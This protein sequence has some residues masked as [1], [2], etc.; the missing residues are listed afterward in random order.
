MKNILVIS[1]SDLSIDPRVNRQ[2][3]T[4]SKNYHVFAAGYSFSTLPKI[5]GINIKPKFNNFMQSLQ[6]FMNML[7]RR[8]ESV[9][10]D[11]RMND[12]FNHIKDSIATS[13]IDV[14]YANDISSL[15]LALKLKDV[16]NCKVI[17]DAH[18]YAPREWEDRFFWRIMHQPYVNYLCKKYIPKV[19]LFITVGDRI[20]K[21]YEL[22]FNINK[23][24]VI[25][26]APGEQKALMPSIVGD[27]KIR[28]IHHGAAIRSRKI[29]LMIEMMDYLNDDFSL[30]LM[31][32]PVD[33]KYYKKLIKLASF[34]NINIIEPVSMQEICKKINEY[35]IGVYILD[36]SKNFNHENAL[37][38]KLFEFIQAGLAI[39]IG[40]SYEMKSF[41]QKF[42][43]GVV[44]D[45]FNSKDLAE[46]LMRLSK[47]DIVRFKS[48]AKKAASV[49]NAEN[50]GEKILALVEG[51]LT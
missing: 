50:E 31:L 32:V 27:S 44:S 45:S 4:L 20:A 42:D 30:D 21:E 48:N 34:K 51:L 29:E 17:F 6:K 18:E 9:Y 38:N 23:A 10:W 19:D 24:H 14:I 35:D 41:V 39:A 36:Q 1:F 28:M 47:D 33:Q 16:Y 7:L 12:Y 15:P 13:Y 8:F 2:L 40:P 5:L 46:E 3:H 37:P 49:L 43:L 26:N 11:Y 25:L 22:Q